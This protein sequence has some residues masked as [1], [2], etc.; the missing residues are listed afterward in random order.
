MASKPTTRVEALLHEL[1]I[2]YGHCLPP[3][4]QAALTAE[5]PK[6]ED[7]FVAAVLLAEGLDPAVLDKRARLALTDLVRQW[8][9]DEGRG[10]GTTSGLPVDQVAILDKSRIARCALTSSTDGLYCLRERILKSVSAES[11][12]SGERSPST[13][14]VVPHA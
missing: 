1:C 12:R 8:L 11:P 3:D 13:T 2:G 5:P 9:F 10:K 14:L 6:D 7:A 4:E